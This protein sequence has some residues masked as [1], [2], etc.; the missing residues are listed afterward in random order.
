MTTEFKLAIKLEYDGKAVTSGLDASRS[1]VVN[2]RQTAV[3]AAD[4]IA[5]SFKNVQTSGTA[6]GATF[7]QVATQ[8]TQN[9][10]A[11][12]A[13]TAAIKQQAAAQLEASR[14]AAAAAAARLA[15]T[16][17]AAAGLGDLEKSTAAVGM[18]ARATAAALRQ[19]PAQVTD[20]VVGLQAGQSPLTVLLQQGGQLKDVF[21]G[22]GPAV[23]A[24]GGYV[25]GLISPLTVA[26]ALALG[27]GLAFNAG[28][29]EGEAY[30]RAIIV[31]GNAAG[32]TSD[33]LQQYA[34]NISAVAGTQ[35]AAAEALATIAQT[36]AVADARLQ[37]V[38]DSALRFEKAT[39]QA[40]GETA[41]QFAELAKS[42]LEASVKLNQQYNF[43]TASVYEQIKALQEQGKTTE[44]ANLA[45]ITYADTLKNRSAEI[46]QNIGFIEKRWLAV[47]AAI[48]GVVDATLNLGREAT[49]G[50][51]INEINAKLLV[52]KTNLQDYVAKGFGDDDRL[53]K[54]ARNQIAALEQLRSSTI[55]GT[56]AKEKSAEATAKEVAATQL[57]IKFDKEGEKFESNSVKLKRELAQVEA[58]GQKLI[59]D[60]IKDNLK[61]LLTQ[62]ELNERIAAVKKK[63]R[64]T[65]GESALENALSAELALY[66][67]YADDRTAILAGA[68]KSAESLRKQGLLD[69]RQLADALFRIRDD[70]L[71]DQIAIAELS[72][73]TAGGKKQKAEQQ[74]FL[75]EVAKLNTQREV[76]ERAHNDRLA[77]ID[78]EQAK[79]IREKVADWALEGEAAKK[80]LAVEYALY[81]QTAE[82]RAVALAGIRLETE[83]EKLIADAK[84]AGIPF[85][86]AQA[87]SIRAEAAARGQN[88]GA[89][90]GEQQALAGAQQLRDANRR[91]AAENIL[92]EDARARALLEID[93][94]VWRQR[95]ALAGEGTEAQKRLVAEFS[96]YYQNQLDKPMTDRWK[97]TVERFNSTFRQGFTRLLE[98]GKDK[99]S[100][101][102]KSIMNAFKTE[103]ADQIYRTFLKPFVVKVIGSF[104]GMDAASAGVPG[105][106]GGGIGGGLPGITNLA[107]TVNNGIKLVN[108]GFEGLGVAVRN[109]VGS[110]ATSASQYLIDAGFENAAQYVANSFNATSS[111]IA[112]GATAI[113]GALV[114]A[115]A[116]NIISGGYSAIGKNSNLAVGIGTAIGSFFGPLGAVIGG[117]IGGLVNRVFGRK[118]TETGIKGTFDASG[119]NGVNY[120]YEKGGLFRSD[121]ER[122]QGPVDN[123]TTNLLNQAFSAVKTSV[124]GLAQQLGVGRDAI[125]GFSTSVRLNF[126]GLDEDGISKLLA[127]TLGE[128]GNELADVVLAQTAG[129][130]ELAIRGETSIQ[131][132]TRLADLIGGVNDVMDFLNIGMFDLSV[133]GVK[134]AQSFVDLFGGLENFSRVT[135]VYYENF[136]SEAEKQAIKLERVT[137]ALSQLASAGAFAETAT[138]YQA[139]IAN[140]SRETYRAL[141]EAQNVN[142]ELGRTTTVALLGLAGAV[143]E[144]APPIEAAAQAVSK[145]FEFERVSESVSIVTAA[146][147]ELSDAERLLGAERREQ[148]DATRRLAEESKAAL[149]LFGQ[150]GQGLNKFAFGIARAT[151]DLPRDQQLGV[152]RN[153]IN[154]L[155]RE[156]TLDFINVNDIETRRRE[157]L[158]LGKTYEQVGQ[159]QTRIA[160]ENKDGLGQLVGGIR[161]AAARELNAIATDPAFDL[162]E[163]ASRAGLAFG[164][165]TSDV[166][167]LN[168]QLAAGAL[169][170]DAYAEAMAQ[171]DAYAKLANVDA[172]GYVET[173]QL[174]SA[175]YESTA[176]RL[177]TVEYAFEQ[178]GAEAAKLTAS[179][180]GLSNLLGQLSS[181][182]SVFGIV[183]DDAAK[184]V[185]KA[186]GTVYGS[187]VSSLP[188]YSSN[189]GQYAGLGSS[190]IAAL[191]GVSQ[192]NAQSFRDAFIILSDELGNGRISVE[193]YEAAIAGANGTFTGAAQAA[194]QAA[195]QLADAAVSQSESLQAELFGL[196]DTEEQALARKREAIFEANKALYDLVEGLK[197]AKAAEEERA[198]RLAQIASEGE[199]LDTRLL[200]LQGN[201]AALRERELA[202]LFEENRGKLRA[203][204]ALEDQQAAAEAAAQAQERLVAAQ[205]R[206][207]DATRG[208]VDAQRNLA[209]F[210][211]DLASQI[212][213]VRV[214]AGQELNQ[215][216]GGVVTAIDT[217]R[218]ASET[219]A[220]RLTSAQTQAGEQLRTTMRQVADSVGEYLRDLAGTDAGSATLSQRRSFNGGRFDDLAQRAI[221]GD[222]TAGAEVAA[223][224][225]QYIDDVRASAGSALEFQREDLRVR[226]LLAQV[227]QRNLVADEDVADSTNS[228]A[229]AQ[230]EAEA[231]AAA[232]TSAVLQAAAA[233]VSYAASTEDAS[234]RF[235]A[236][237]GSFA[238]AQTT[239]DAVQGQ[240]VNTEATL[241]ARYAGL[242]TQL[243]DFEIRTTGLLEG[244]EPLDPLGELLNTYSTAVSTLLEA[245]QERAAAGAA[246]G[247]TPTV[248]VATGAP[249]E[250]ATP[251]VVLPA[252]GL[253]QLFGG[254]FLGGGGSEDRLA[255]LE[256]IL[257]LVVQ[258]LQDARTE[259]QVA[260]VNTGK[261]E[262]SLRSVLGRSRSTL[263]VEIVSPSTEETTT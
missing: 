147:R 69:E 163:I 105:A 42:P 219:A 48:G 202:G 262:R 197:A 175:A 49:A 85:S 87:A 244:L 8:I 103:V 149:T 129:L 198:A 231:A 64:D 230:A 232:Y 254:A 104:L 97:A 5:V 223:A 130:K 23:R 54:G 29:K 150:T 11:I 95:I 122:E 156:L 115:I 255:A 144:I 26:I 70:A 45:Q 81:G 194:E 169:T 7:N 120:T 143:A 222:A 257:T 33:K 71:V 3:A 179:G 201:T 72:A 57:K 134:A 107:S 113:G 151:N 6:V 2:F 117:A 96:V 43:L 159:L 196:L 248:A 65:D 181:I 177:I 116:G 242:T 22:V 261:T 126:K 84:R 128:I 34:R 203:I 63:Y 162:G 216:R 158:D 15:A 208:V 94:D 124:A 131:T 56:Q 1:G 31:S 10:A 76:N 173:L 207:V 211:E 123:E 221:G 195:K 112:A 251:T 101:F 215:A 60:R 206:V 47:K 78:A 167:T 39:G 188:G 36:G 243:E 253:A 200:Q 153:A 176:R 62:A 21:G 25:L 111:G 146:T 139:F 77:E 118:L 119:F 240:L 67:G 44:A 16:K 102:N 92:D 157:L 168:S 249:A 135:A 75:G 88:A 30:S 89:I 58:D 236:A 80:A 239:F 61:P 193:Q 59:G 225:R 164:A 127:D 205:E 86:E 17:T 109:G 161:D 51:K 160:L 37:Q 241:I 259:F 27:I 234:T 110:F 41:K 247:T 52:L 19:V 220:D 145:L 214:Q 187:V 140:Q 121:R 148:L 55:A 99:W 100:A 83:A 13:N 35:G 199:A 263:R 38:A 137:G 66:K 235:N 252:T 91:F 32:T 114:G 93:A 18:S 125:D 246:V 20:I 14:A 178:I 68:E 170:Q 74:R 209:K 154:Q 227:Q 228:L 165:Y 108:L 183:N 218:Q 152:A 185:S 12:S 184:A 224:A 182:R 53:V 213:S 226:A 192:G 50:D 237:L 260:A 132:L 250:L 166:M 106:E 172:R 24:L 138:E 258:Q 186:A 233:G 190:A 133:A 191:G 174:A 142:T 73:A 171:V 28:Q 141:L 210:G 189:P 212:N 40:V 245:T 155:I 4:S 238:A 229:T 90:A 180:G 136:F 82:A 256:R 217:L 46:L 98:G 9:T 204:Q 79:R